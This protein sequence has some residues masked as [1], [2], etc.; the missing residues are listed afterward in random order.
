MAGRARDRI[1]D[2]HKTCISATMA[3]VIAGVNQWSSPYALW[4]RFEGQEETREESYAMRRGSFMEPGLIK[5]FQR[6]TK[7]R[8]RRPRK[9]FDE[10]FWFTTDQYGFPMGALLDGITTDSTGEAV[11]EAKT[12][13]QFASG[14]WL[15]KE[16]EDASANDRVPLIYFLQCQHQLAVTGWQHAYVPADVGGTFCWRLVKR[17]DEVIALLTDRERDFWNNHVLTHKPPEV[18]GHEATSAAI[19]RRWPT[20]TPEF[21]EENYDPEI[22]RLAMRYR[23]EG[24]NIS[25]LKK[26][27]DGTGNQLRVI[28]EDREALMTEHYKVSYKTYTKKQFDLEAFRAAHPALAQEF[29]V[30]KEQR[31][32]KVTERKDV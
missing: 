12:A 13:N 28:L 29:T 31:P 19:L 11:V 8:V 14:D 3:S 5:E 25:R 24:D 21:I 10:R 1:E 9:V 17:D 16:H 15:Y 23:A 7:L 18:D 27:R 30:E 2:A 4:A 20:S 32:L 6:E 22:E 26:E